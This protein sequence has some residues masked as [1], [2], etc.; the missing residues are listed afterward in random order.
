MPA[1]DRFI[2]N[3]E[4]DA[5]VAKQIANATAAVEMADDESKR[6]VAR[7]A[8][9]LAQRRHDGHIATHAALTV[10]HGAYVIGLPRKTR[11]KSQQ[12]L[13]AEGY[14]GIYRAK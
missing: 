1:P 13:T 5:F 14:V 7:A 8:A 6:T 12:Q 10:E 2:T 4:S 9:E 3:L 11:W